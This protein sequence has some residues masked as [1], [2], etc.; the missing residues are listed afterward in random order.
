[1]GCRPRRKSIRRR[2]DARSAV[3]VVVPPPLPVALDAGEVGAAPDADSTSLER[4]A[5]QRRAAVAVHHRCVALDDDATTVDVVR[6]VVAGGEAY[7]GPSAFKGLR[8]MRISVCNGWTSERDV[9]RTMVAVS[10]A[11]RE[12]RA[13]RTR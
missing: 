10:D 12:S 9:D 5:D 6:R 3:G 13:D 4:L 7:L 8:V 11:L 2:S 1:M